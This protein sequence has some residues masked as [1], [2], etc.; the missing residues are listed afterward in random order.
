MLRRRS[1][2]Q[3]DEDRGV[4][5][6]DLKFG[7]SSFIGKQHEQSEDGGDHRSRPR[8]PCRRGPRP[9]ARNDADRTGGGPGGRPLRAA[10]AA[11]PVVL[12][13][14]IQRRQGRRASA[15]ADG[16]EFSGPAG[17]PDR[18]RTPRA[19]HRTARDKDRAAR[20]DP[21]LQPRHRRRACGLRQGE[22]Q[23]PRD[24]ALR[25][26][27]PERQGSGDAACRR[28]DRRIRHMGLAES[29]RR[30]RPDRDRR[31]RGRSAD[32]VWHARCPR[33]GTGP[34]RRQDRRGSRGGSLGDRYAD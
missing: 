8:R 31:A 4:I 24:G 30:W 26:P 20:R 29:C 12:A 18:R 2:E 11:R 3:G 25:D 21:Y 10:V 34:L 13:V 7:I 19:L 32:F 23:G 6:L 5:S 1:C 22:D 28:R 27:I 33:Q 9:G 15:R 16:M 17:L 14:G